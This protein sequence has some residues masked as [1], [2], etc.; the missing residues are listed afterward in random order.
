MP[1]ACT[2]SNPFKQHRRRRHTESTA[3]TVY[4]TH[5]ASR[6]RREA[7]HQSKLQKRCMR[8]HLY[9]ITFL[10][11]HISCVQ[12]LECRHQCTPTCSCRK[13]CVSVRTSCR[14]ENRLRRWFRLAAQDGLY[15]SKCHHAWTQRR[16]RTRA[17]AEHTSDSEVN[18]HV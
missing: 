6:S 2:Y 16:L 7:L 14:L 13:Q 9:S 1:T 8:V 10:V 15:Q 4:S 11:H 18:T 12:A 3:L 5:Q 17:D